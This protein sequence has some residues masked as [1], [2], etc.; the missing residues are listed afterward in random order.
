MWLCCNRLSA[1]GRFGMYGGYFTL[2]F[3]WVQQRL[4]PISLYIRFCSW[5]GHHGMVLRTR[6]H[7]VWWLAGNEA[8]A[9]AQ[10]WGCDSNL[11]CLMSHRDRS[12]PET[13]RSTFRVKP[14]IHAH[15]TPA[16]QIDLH[17]RWELM[18]IAL[19]FCISPS[20]SAL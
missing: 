6:R 1:E 20:P 2:V 17:E 8:L 12:P 7:K 13:H 10:L 9:A 15:P 16:Q 18:N 3:Q 19:H 11:I 14:A 4:P 5:W